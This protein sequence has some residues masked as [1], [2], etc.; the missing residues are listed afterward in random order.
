MSLLEAFIT[1]SAFMI[2]FGDNVTPA[3]VDL[4]A[5]FTLTVRGL[6][7]PVDYEYVVMTAV[8]PPYLY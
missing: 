4:A 8:E 3:V 1:L 7:L 6:F 2:F 5:S